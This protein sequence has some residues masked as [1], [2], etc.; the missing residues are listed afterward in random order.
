M[1]GGNPD[2]AREHFQRCIEISEGKFLL[3]KVY[4]AQYYAAP[5]L[6]EKLF[7]ETLN[8]VL[9]APQDVLPDYELLTS[10]AK[11][12]AQTLLQNKEEFF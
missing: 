6:N 5:T 1:L 11:K 9:D 4:Y 2:K 10:L 3:A 8:E 7:E 12:R